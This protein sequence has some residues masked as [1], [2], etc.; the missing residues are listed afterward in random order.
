MA[1]FDAIVEKRPT[2]RQVLGAAAT[3]AGSVAVGPLL[4]A[5]GS[6]ST[7]SSTSSS[8]GL[9]ASAKLDLSNILNAAKTTPKFVPPGPSV[10]AAKAAGKTI[11]W[12]ALTMNVPIEQEWWTGIQ[13]ACAAA[14]LQAV[15]FDGKGQ[16]SEIVRGLE[17]AIAQ[18]VDCIITD[19]IGSAT[20]AP[21]IAKAQSAGI[22][23]I[24]ANERN[25]AFGGPTVKSVDGD[26][27][28]NYAGAAKLEA[29]WVLA[30]SGGNANVVVFKLPNAPA[31]DDMVS[32]IMQEFA[33]YAPNTAK[34][35][36][37]ETV[38]VPDWA[39][40][41]PVLARSLATAHPEMNYMIPL[42]DFPS[43]YI[44]PALHQAGLAN[45]IKI[46][47]F[48]G[49]PT[50]LQLLKNGNVVGGD[51]GGANTWESWAEIDLALR[52]LT[53]MPKVSYS[54]PLRL[55]DN[56]NIDSID[57]NAPTGVL[58]YDTASAESGFK[59]LWGVA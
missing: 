41:Y 21:F 52:L 48:N 43:Q 12:Q 25:D 56:S 23:F 9:S 35:I 17:Q 14:G 30:D 11:W 27:A 44:V 15:N 53:G 7:T 50:I 31:H 13:A 54:I 10:A 40:R 24:V 46:S 51:I 22:K 2:R 6:A 42:V 1:G 29:D 36:S 20:I 28:L 5:C 38:A 47:S 18:K 19:S 34:I 57:I 32:V 58:W 39:T 37:V 55:F 26:V 45:K 59:Q 33:K 8:A 16:D 49:T 4:A 3:V